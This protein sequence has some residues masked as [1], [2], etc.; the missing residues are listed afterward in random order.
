ML[1]V[2]MFLQVFKGISVDLWIQPPIGNEMNIFGM[3]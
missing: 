2:S 3:W 1:P